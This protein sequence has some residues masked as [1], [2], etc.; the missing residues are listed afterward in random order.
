MLSADGVGGESATRWRP[1]MLAL[2]LMPLPLL[3]GVVYSLFFQT[4]YR[5][6]ERSRQQ[7]H[8]DLPRASAPRT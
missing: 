4:I 7:T 2:L 3:L 8:Q 5:L 6:R 1:L